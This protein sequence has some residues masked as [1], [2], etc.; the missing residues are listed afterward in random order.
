MVEV[1]YNSLGGATTVTCKSQAPKIAH[2]VMSDVFHQIETW[3]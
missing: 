1:V 2:D 3:V